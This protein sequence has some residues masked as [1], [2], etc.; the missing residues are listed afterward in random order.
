MVKGDPS[1]MTM[2]VSFVMD[3]SRGNPLLERMSRELTSS[4]CPSS[5]HPV[6]LGQGQRTR[7]GGEGAVIAWPPTRG[8]THTLFAGLLKEK[9]RPLDVT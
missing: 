9:H 5:G 3:Q 4:G 7:G 8:A 2:P 6:P 1:N